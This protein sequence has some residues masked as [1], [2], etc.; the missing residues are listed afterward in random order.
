MNLPENVLDGWI[1]VEGIT[2]NALWN[3]YYAEKVSADKI[4]SF[5]HILDKYGIEEI[6]INQRDFRII[7][8][9]TLLRLPFSFPDD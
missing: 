6:T 3:H 8:K 5:S 9:Q 4:V 2:D 7:A 1:P